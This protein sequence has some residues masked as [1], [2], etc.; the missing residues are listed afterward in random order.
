MVGGFS[1]SFCMLIGGYHA[2]VESTWHAMSKQTIPG[3]KAHGRF[4]KAPPG[5]VQTL[6]PALVAPAQK[7]HLRV[8]NCLFISSFE[9]CTWVAS[10]AE[11]WEAGTKLIPTCLPNI[12]QNWG[13]LPDVSVSI[14][15]SAD[16]MSGHFDCQNWPSGCTDIWPWG[17]GAIQSTNK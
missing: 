5:P 10:Q 4:N 7:T 2:T 13:N 11:T 1:T 17:H 12:R 9:I 8:K 6:S 14:T 3:D 16:S 15:S